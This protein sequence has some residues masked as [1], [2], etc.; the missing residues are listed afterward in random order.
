ME[1]SA[2]GK[3]I[4]AIGTHTD[5]TERMESEERIRNLLKEK[6]LLLRKLTTVS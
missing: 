1:R 3:P 6:E 4:R 5:I 2:D